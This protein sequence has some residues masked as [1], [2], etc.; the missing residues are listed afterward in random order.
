MNI[1]LTLSQK[2]K[3]QR[4]A[5]PLTQ[6]DMCALLGIRHRSN[7]SRIESGKQE[8]SISTLLAYHLI[9]DIPIFSNRFDVELE[10]MKQYLKIR[11][12]TC[13]QNLLKDARDAG[14]HERI[15]F[16]T[17]VYERIKN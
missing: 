14:V 12:D 1:Q 9:F 4:E 15:E 10:R 5:S 7:L 11:I 2:L 3:A 16:L 8:A 17:T 13:I 6:S